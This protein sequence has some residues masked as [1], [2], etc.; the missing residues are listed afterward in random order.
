VASRFRAGKIEART[1]R[2]MRTRE[3]P[4]LGVAAYADIESMDSPSVVMLLRI[5]TTGNVT[6]VRI[7]H[8]SGT[9]DIDLPCQRAAYTWWFEPLKDPKTGEVRPEIIEFTIYF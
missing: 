4:R 9:D 2:K 8:S 5:D 6:D 7:E 1:G 3:L